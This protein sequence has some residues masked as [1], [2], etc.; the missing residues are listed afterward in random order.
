MLH[1]NVWLETLYLE[2]NEITLHGATAIMKGSPLA[3]YVIIKE[4]ST[5]GLP[6]TGLLKNKTIE[7]VSL[8]G[9]PIDPRHLLGLRQRAVRFIVDKKEQVKVIFLLLL[10]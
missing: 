1:C 9:N 3:R 5:Q 10:V 7:K 6:F 8:V 2:D 4:A